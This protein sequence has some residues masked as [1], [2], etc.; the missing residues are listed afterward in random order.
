MVDKKTFHEDPEE[1][2]SIFVEEYVSKYWK[3]P[4]GTRSTG[5]ILID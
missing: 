4:R 5:F 2:S 3:I 1:E